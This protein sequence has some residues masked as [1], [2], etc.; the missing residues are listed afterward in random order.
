[1]PRLLLAWCGASRLWSGAAP[2]RALIWPCSRNGV[3]AHR[4]AVQGDVINGLKVNKLSSAKTQLPFS[5]YSLPYCRPD[6]IVSS[7][8]NL[9]EVLRGDRIFNSKYQVRFAARQGLPEA[10]EPRSCARHA[11]M[12]SCRCTCEW[13]RRARCCAARCSTQPRPRS[14]RR[15]WRRSTGST[16]AQLAVSA[17]GRAP[18]RLC[19]TA[20][21]RKDVPCLSSPALTCFRSACGCIMRPLRILW[22][23]CL[24]TTL[25]SQPAQASNNAVTVFSKPCR[26]LDNLPVAMVR[27]K[28]RGDED[29]KIYDRGFP[30]GIKA[31]A[32]EVVRRPLA[33]APRARA[34]AACG[35]A[36]VTCTETQSSRGHAWLVCGG[37][38]H[39][40][41]DRPLSRSDPLA[42]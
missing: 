41:T 33:R 7:A 38:H 4:P 9:G 5:Y 29:I 30:V 25:T 23:L 13:T 31:P 20:R 15:E 10:L 1:M 37:G 6:K 3:P 32:A 28:K 35:M 14:F 12:S 24:S 19:T 26:I 2:L 40:A 39:V 22:R 18:A 8:E 16:C 11:Q 36:A 42:A 17:I 21:D 27:W 34:M